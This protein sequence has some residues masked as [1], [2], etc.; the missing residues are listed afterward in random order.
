MMLDYW[1]LGDPW[2]PRLGP[3]GVVNRPVCL[4]PRPGA[5][6]PEVEGFR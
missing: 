4:G 6:D 2:W 1:A 3:V 5:A